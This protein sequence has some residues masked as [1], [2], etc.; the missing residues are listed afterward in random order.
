MFSY[1]SLLCKLYTCVT[2]KYIKTKEKKE[3]EEEK[4]R[5]ILQMLVNVLQ[6]KKK[7]I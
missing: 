7:W 5:N 2:V 1:Y 6:K 3:E 4:T